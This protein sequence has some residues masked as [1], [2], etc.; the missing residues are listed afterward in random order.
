MPSLKRS[1]SNASTVGGLAGAIASKVRSGPITLVL[2][3]ILTLAPKS[4][5]EKL[6]RTVK[7]K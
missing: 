7:I 5:P 3:A 2:G 6:H 4:D 1:V